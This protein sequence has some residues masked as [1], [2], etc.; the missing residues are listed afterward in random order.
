[1]DDRFALLVRGPR[2]AQRRQQTLAGSI[3]WS[4]ALLDET[5]RAV[6]RRLAVFAGTFGLDAAARSLVRGEP[7]PTA[8]VLPALGRLVD[9]SLVMAEEH[10]G[11]SRYRL[12]ETIRAYAAARLAEAQEDTAAAR[13]APRPGTSSSPRPRSL[14]REPTPDRWRR[15][16]QLEYDNLRAALDWGAGG[17]DPD[18]GRRLAASLAWLWHLD[19]RGREGIG[20]LRRAIERAPDERSALQARLLTGA[21]PRRSTPRARSTSSTTPRPVRSSWRRR[22]A[23]TG[24]ARCASTW[25]PV[26]AFYTDFDEAWALAD[27]AS[28]SAPGRER[29]DERRAPGRCRR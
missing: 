12:L 23:T 14:A 28:R 6:F 11:E 29:A 15:A 22:P 27:Q 5:D 4:H 8:E 19:R 26:G 3:D 16:L 18:A 1:M 7:V 17:G 25:P 2:G 13:P 20:Y 10:A 21:R 24:S 9:K